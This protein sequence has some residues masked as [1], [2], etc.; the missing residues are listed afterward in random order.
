MSSPPL[1]PALALELTRRLSQD[2]EFRDLF[3]QNPVAALIQVGLSPDR[4][5]ALRVCCK[6]GR[7]ASKQAIL[8]A[9][10]EIQTMLT[11]GLGQIVPALDANPKGRHLKSP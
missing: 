7:L 1:E 8:E 9:Q 3:R 11:A 2:D 10:Q 4:A 6:V 5:D